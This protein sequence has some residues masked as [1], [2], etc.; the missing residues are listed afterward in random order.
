[1]L[2]RPWLVVI[3]LLRIH[4]IFTNERPFGIVK[5]SQDWDSQT[6]ATTDKTTDLATNDTEHT[7]LALGNTKAAP[8]KRSYVTRV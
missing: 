4:L 7:D 2:C 8:Q 5:V 6:C 3:P 1:M